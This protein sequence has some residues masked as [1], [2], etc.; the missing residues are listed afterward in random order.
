MEP[1]QETPDQSFLPRSV[2]EVVHPSGLNSQLSSVMRVEEEPSRMTFQN[3][4]PKMEI[5]NG[6]PRPIEIPF[7][8]VEKMVAAMDTDQ[9]ECVSIEELKNYIQKHRVP[10][11]D[12]LIVDMFAEA[13]SKRAYVHIAQREKPLTAEEIYNCVRGRESKDVQTKQWGISYRPFR[14]HWILLLQKVNKKVFVHSEVREIPY[15]DPA[16]DLKAQY[17][18]GI[19]KHKAKRMK[20]FKVVLPLR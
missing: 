6:R 7:E 11:E 10:F 4:F 2:P 14:D 1:V 12:D 13:V 15:I 3:D 9:D 19:K 18:L 16:K 5:I 20:D 17:Q 8:C